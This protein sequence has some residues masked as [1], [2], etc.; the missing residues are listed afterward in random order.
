MLNQYENKLHAAYLGDSLYMILR[1]NENTSLFEL[2]FKSEDQFHK[3]NQPYQV[4]T[5][6]DSP[7]DAITNT[8]NI[9]HKDV[10]IVATDGLWDNL[11]DDDII[12][13]INKSQNE[14]FIEDYNEI[15]CNLAKKAELNSYDE[16]YS[17]PFS[18]KA[19]EFGINYIGGKIDDITI[20]VS[21]ITA[22]ISFSE[23]STKDN[24]SFYSNK[25][26]NPILES[27]CKF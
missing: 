21:Q 7:H 11:Y 12:Q 5:N 27:D 24:E 2:N 15:A 9:Q 17:S 25:E 13:F 23:S 14:G 19:K 22:V 26:S 20:V 10:I 6:G 4:G 18:A 1:F 16:H 8:H 3:F